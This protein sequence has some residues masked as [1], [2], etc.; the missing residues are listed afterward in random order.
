MYLKNLK[1]KEELNDE[2][3]L[4]SAYNNIAN[5][6][7]DQKDPKNALIYQHKV[8]DIYAKRGDSMYLA[9]IMCNL[10]NSHFINPKSTK[11]IG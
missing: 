6:Y 11:N 3:G 10:G 2:M 1:I 8:Y 5:L 9:Q 4:A 7:N